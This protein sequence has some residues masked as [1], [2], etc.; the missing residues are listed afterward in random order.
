M[1]YA[2]NVLFDVGVVVVMFCSGLAFSELIRRWPYK[3]DEPLKRVPM[4]KPNDMVQRPPRRRPNHNR[5][6]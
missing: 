2:V 1:I 6:R 3:K 4:P 5:D